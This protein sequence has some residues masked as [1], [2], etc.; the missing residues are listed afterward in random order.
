MSYIRIEGEYL[1]IEEEER[2]KEEEKRIK[3][4]YGF[5]KEEVWKDG[6]CL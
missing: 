3:E 5:W 4:V 6:G 2:L 1:R